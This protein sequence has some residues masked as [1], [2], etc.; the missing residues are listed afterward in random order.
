MLSWRSDQN[1]ASYTTAVFLPEKS[2]VAMNSRTPP[3]VIGII[4]Y[5]IMYDIA[6]LKIE[7]EKGER[8]IEKSLSLRQP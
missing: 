5:K 3:H 8:I 4:F 6:E 1:I 7:E 2:S